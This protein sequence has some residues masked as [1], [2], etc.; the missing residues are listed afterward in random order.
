MSEKREA[1]RSTHIALKEMSWY[2]LDS[3][4]ILSVINR[5]ASKYSDN[6]I[7]PYAIFYYQNWTAKK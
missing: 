5:Y 7:I 3:Y 4:T 1:V 6:K 2:T